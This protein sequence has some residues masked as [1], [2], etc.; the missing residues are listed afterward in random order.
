MDLDLDFIVHSLD[1]ISSSRSF[2]TSSLRNILHF[3]F[4]NVVRNNYSQYD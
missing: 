1:S 4:I 2:D 3:E